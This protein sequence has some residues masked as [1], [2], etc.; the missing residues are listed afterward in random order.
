M[1]ITTQDIIERLKISR[2]TLHYM[3]GK[4]EFIRGIKFGRTVRFSE[5]EFEKWIVS[6]SHH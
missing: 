6:Q 4:G 3:R 1:F 2:T 5:E